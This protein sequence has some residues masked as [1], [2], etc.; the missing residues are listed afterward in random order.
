MEKIRYKTVSKSVLG[1]LHTPVSVYLKVRDLYHQSA[2]MESS[3]YHSSENN[4]SFIGLCPLASIS[5]GHGE[6][7]FTYPDKS[8]VRREISDTYSVSD[9]FA[10][11]LGAF[12]VE[13][14]YAKYCGLYGY[15]SFSAVRYFENIPIKDS[16]DDQ[17][18]AADIHYIL[19]K[20]LIVFKD[21]QNEMTLVE[22]LGAGEQSQ[23]SKVEQA[24]RKSDIPSYSFKAVGELSST[25]TDEE[26]KANIR[27]GIA[28][29]LRGA[30]FQIVLSRRFVQPFEGDDFVVYRALRAIN[31]SP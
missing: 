4:R 16:Y 9:A 7:K 27:R 14:D 1:D 8:V 21:S 30:V 26:H 13:G 24:I 5:V 20:Y 25:L 12:E 15:T 10:E 6:V 11:F 31:P 23:L 17:H 19:Y 29:C 18:D 22:L 3:D 28:H 2:L